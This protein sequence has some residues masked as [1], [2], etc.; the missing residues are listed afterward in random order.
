MMT[1]FKIQIRKLL[2]IDHS[3]HVVKFNKFKMVRMAMPGSVLKTVTTKYLNFLPEI[4][5]VSDG[6]LK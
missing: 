6:M 2:I 4:Q 5:C 1:S 3:V